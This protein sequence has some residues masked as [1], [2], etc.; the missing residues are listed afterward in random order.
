MQPGTLFVV[1]TPIG[2]LDDVSA[3]AL[4]VLASVDVVLAEDTRHTAKLLERH[5]VRARSVSLH[6]H[7]EDRVAPDLVARMAA[8][9]SM[10]LVCDAGTPLVSDP[11]YRLVRLTREGGVR[12][13]PVPGPSALIAALSVAGLPTD[14]FAFEGFLPARAGARRRRLVDLAA[15]T[16]TLVFYEAPHRVVATVADL[17]AAF[18]G[19]REAVLAREL[20]KRFETVHG[21]S[22]AALPAWLAERPERLRGEFVIVVAGAAPRAASDRLDDADQHVLAVLADALPAREAA[23]LAARITGQARN[24]LYRALLERRASGPIEEG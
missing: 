2:N 13:S 11:G 22:L 19:E 1:A 10:A 4:E 12:V 14:R 24:R 3:R 15:E 8:G 7:N 21:G 9:E 20:T 16:R 5:R 6:D 17:A 23:A 18:G